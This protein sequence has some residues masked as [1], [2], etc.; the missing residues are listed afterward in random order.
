M[1]AATERTLSEA[2][3]FLQCLRAE[4]TKPVRNEPEAFSFY[5][6][7]LLSAARSVTF[8][9][10]FEE[11]EKDDAWFPEWFA[12]RGDDDHTRTRR[13]LF[14]GSDGACLARDLRV[15]DDEAVSGA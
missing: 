6:S 7:A 15:L 14:G 4:S 9:L 11:K 2:Q 12:K 8:A 10:Q 13:L 5:L 3:F 1:I